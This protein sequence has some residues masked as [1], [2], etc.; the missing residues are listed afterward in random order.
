M[1]E[2]IFNLLQAG[3]LFILFLLLILEGNPIIGFFI[4][5]SVV[6]IFYGFFISAQQETSVSTALLV[7]ALGFTIP[8]GFEPEL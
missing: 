3:G 4:P 7:I 1:F 6:V 8:E 5:G 2:L